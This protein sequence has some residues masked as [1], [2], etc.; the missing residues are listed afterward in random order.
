MKKVILF[1]LLICFSFIVSAQELNVMTFNIRLNTASD[2]LNAWPYRKDKTASQILFH[3]IHLLG[4]QE[5][6]HDQ[7]KDLKERLTKYKYVGGGRDDGKEKGEYSAIFYDTARLQLLQ[8]KMFWLSGTPEVPGSKSW[9]AAITRMVTWAKF[10]DRKTKKIFFAF[11]THFDHVG[12]VARRESAMIVLNKVK[13]IAGNIPVVFTG[14]FNSRPSDEPIQIIL[15]KTNPLHLT[16]SKEIS[17]TPH[18]G[19][20]GTFNGFR[21]KEIENEPIDYIFLK[22]K[23]KVLTHATISQ[24]W[25]GRFA[26]DHF[27]VIARIKLQ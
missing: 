15:D 13:E 25:G 22:G 9:D 6:L 18:Y 17:L 2:S 11:N 8:T 23:W 12:K 27:S 1:F 20:T 14:D 7:M 21:S 10:R 5:A 16:D 19:P 26:S 4:V 3:G 24:T